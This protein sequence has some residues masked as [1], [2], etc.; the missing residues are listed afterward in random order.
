MSTEANKAIVHR[1][2]EAVWNERNL[3]LIDEV[4]APDFVQHSAGVPPGR[5]GV[6]QF[7]HMIETAFPDARMT[8]EDIIA[9][10]DRVVWRF[11]IHATHTGLFQGIPPTGRSV[12]ITGMN[13]VRMA[14]SRIVENWGQQDSLGLLQQLGV[15]S[16]PKQAST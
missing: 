13:I 16:A 3:A 5:A 10:A 2:V 15:L 8:I 1:Y 12:T 14:D 9:E 7:F 4:I 6:T 11:S